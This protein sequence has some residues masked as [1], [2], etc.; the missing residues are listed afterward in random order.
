MRRKPAGVDKSGSGAVVQGATVGHNRST[1]ETDDVTQQS[2]RYARVAVAFVAADRPS[3]AELDQSELADAVFV[4]EG[5]DVSVEDME[6]QLALV[7]EVAVGD[8]A[9]RED[10]QIAKG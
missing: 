5:G 8:A 9:K 10:I 1:E 3:Q 7:P 4:H 6:D 2:A